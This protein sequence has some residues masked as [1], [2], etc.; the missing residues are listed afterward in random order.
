MPRRATQATTRS[1]VQER[2]RP[3]PHH[4]AIP[5]CQRPP[6][7]S[8]CLPLPPTAS[9]CLG[10]LLQGVSALYPAASSEIWPQNSVFVTLSISA[11][12]VLPMCCPCATHVLT[13]CYPC[14]DHVLTT[15]TMWFRDIGLGT[16]LGIACHPNEAEMVR[17]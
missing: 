17:H 3:F 13:M 11:A 4:R 7:A 2:Q 8:H 9:H 12:H 16:W 10:C 5:A 1:S 6:T 15:C 14:A